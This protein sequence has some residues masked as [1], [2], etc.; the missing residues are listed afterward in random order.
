V[1]TNLRLPIG[2]P[3]DL[4]ARAYAV[5]YMPWPAWTQPDS[6]A[7]IEAFRSLSLAV[8][9]GELGVRTS[10]GTQTHYATA[11]GD[12]VCSFGSLERAPEQSWEDFVQ[13]SCDA[14]SELVREFRP[15]HPIVEPCTIGF[16][17]VWRAHTNTG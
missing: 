7:A 15:R 2:F 10:S 5:G 16:M 3:V 1:S 9:D 12:F 17:L 8:T 13:S 4:A 11:E 6:V 14:V